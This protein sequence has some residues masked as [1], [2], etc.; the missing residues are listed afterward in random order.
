MLGGVA[1]F[2]QSFAKRAWLQHARSGRMALQPLGEGGGSLTT[3]L[4]WLCVGV[5]LIGQLLVGLFSTGLA[6]GEERQ[7]GRALV[8]RYDGRDAAARRRQLSLIATAWLSMRREL[9][10]TLCLRQRLRHLRASCAAP[11][12][13]SRQPASLSGC[14]CLLAGR[15]RVLVSQDVCLPRGRAGGGG[16]VGLSGRGRLTGALAR[17]R[18]ACGCAGRGLCLLRQG[19]RVPQGLPDLAGAL[20][21]RAA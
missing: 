10:C 1:S 5:V 20:P 16:L 21:G 8:P 13:C 18:G 15:A 4:R 2:Y 12:C 9:L 6:G 11:S 14:L 3:G 7:M 19:G 17:G